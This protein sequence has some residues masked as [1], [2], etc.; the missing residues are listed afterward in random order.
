MA[1]KTKFKTVKSVAKRFKATRRGK[2]KRNRAYA[3][4]L[5][6]C[7]SPKQ[8]RRLRRTATVD[9]NQVRTI[10]RALGAR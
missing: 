10:L 9:R 2:V 5:K 8:R 3:R 4:H 7:K 1:T 6:A